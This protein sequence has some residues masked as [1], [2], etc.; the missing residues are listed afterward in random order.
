[1][2]QQYTTYI[3]L[4]HKTNLGPTRES[5][6]W[7]RSTNKIKKKKTLKHYQGLRNGSEVKRM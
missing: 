7:N 4:K 5:S 3:E 6:T 1:M 2:F